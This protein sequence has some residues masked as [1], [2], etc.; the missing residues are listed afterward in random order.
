MTLTAVV[1]V[2]TGLVPAPRWGALPTEVREHCSCQGA[3]AG[4]ASQTM[5]SWTG[6][7]VNLQ[8]AG[9]MVTSTKGLTAV[10][11]SGVFGASAPVYWR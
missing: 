3:G 11:A 9:P 5:Q 4:Q 6:T 8:T 10:G 7:G 2:L 1:I